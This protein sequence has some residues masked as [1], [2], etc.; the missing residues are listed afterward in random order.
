MPSCLIRFKALWLPTHALQKAWRRE[1]SQVNRLTPSQQAGG[2]CWCFTSRSS[3]VVVVV[4]VD[5]GGLTMPCR[6]TVLQTLECTYVS[7]QLLALQYGALPRLQSTY[8]GAHFLCNSMH[9]LNAER[10]GSNKAYI[11]RTS[12]CQRL[13]HAFRSS[14]ITRSCSLAPVPEECSCR[15]DWKSV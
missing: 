14:V 1:L 10:N 12:T 15:T 4:V 5:G 9:A 7:E 2:V 3:A 6:Y 11:Y 13:A 8:L